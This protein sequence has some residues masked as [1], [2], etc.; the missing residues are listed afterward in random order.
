MA[1]PVMPALDIPITNA[2]VNA[3]DQAVMEISDVRDCTRVDV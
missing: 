3:I 2:A 1:I